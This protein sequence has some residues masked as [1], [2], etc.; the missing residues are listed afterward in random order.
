MFM[1][2]VFFIL[3][4]C[5]LKRNRIRDPVRTRD[6]N[7]KKS[8][9]CVRMKKKR[10]SPF[11][12]TAFKVA[13]F[14]HAP[15]HNCSATLQHHFLARANK[16]S[17]GLSLPPS[18]TPSR[19]THAIHSDKALDLLHGDVLVVGVTLMV[20]FINDGDSISP[21]SSHLVLGDWR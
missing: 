1:C 14:A 10:Y 9:L 4:P 20:I 8:F 11:A 12:G 13:S 5:D 19:P 7:R 2:F 6:K 3:N 18:G 15:A 16:T 21:H 17:G